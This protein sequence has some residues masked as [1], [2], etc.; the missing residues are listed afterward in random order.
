MLK[1]DQSAPRVR[2]HFPSWLHVDEHVLVC[3]QQEPLMQLCL[4]SAPG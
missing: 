1:L 2:G 4:W 3:V